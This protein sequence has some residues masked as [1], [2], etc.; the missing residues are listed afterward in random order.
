MVFIVMVADNLKTDILVVAKKDGGVQYA[1]M[2]CVLNVTHVL[3]FHHLRLRS[4]LQLK[5]SDP[6]D[7]SSE[8]TTSEPPTNPAFLSHLFF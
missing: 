8:P 2:I 6:P 5:L 3:L 7:R 1:D 4:V